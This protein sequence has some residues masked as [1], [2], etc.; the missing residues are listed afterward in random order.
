M[1][2]GIE[3]IWVGSYTGQ[4]GEGEGIG[5]LGLAGAGHLAWNGVAAK[6]E[7]PSFLA[8]H[9]TLP[10]LYAVAEFE[11]TVQ[12]YRVQD[13]DAA[14]SAAN[15]TDLE[16][17]GEPW[18]AG[19]AAC[20]IAVDPSGHF[21]VV[22]C[23]G[24]GDVLYYELDEA[25][26]IKSRIAAPAAADPYPQQP[27][28]EPRVSRAHATL[29]LPNGTLLTTDL[30]FDLLRIWNVLPGVGLVAVADIP[31]GY[32]SGPRHLVMHPSGHVYVVTEYSIEVVVLA[33]DASAG[34]VIIDRVPASVGG[35]NEGDSAAEITIDAAGYHVHVSVRGS[36]IIS[37]LAVYAD[38]AQLQ[39]VNDADCGGDIPR[40]HV[41]VGNVIL[42]ANQGSSTVVSLALDAETGVP[43]S[44]IDTLSVGTPTCLVVAR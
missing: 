9:P 29:V 21:L 23:W 14:A 4:A 5:S 31:L 24:S 26:A 13:V 32:G 40:H 12:A 42:V 7:S 38:G 37:T 41:Q 36:N 19:A 20:H 34:F 6:A 1:V 2:T 16:A 10:L 30:G 3:R 11:A 18:P 17:V 22:T 33:P 39:A 44:I 27:N 35:V 43:T 15:A 8:L 28:A 25:G